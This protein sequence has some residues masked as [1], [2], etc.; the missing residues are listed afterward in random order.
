MKD[1]NNVFLIGRQTRD[2]S[3]YDYGMTG[4]GNA[5]LNLSLAVNNSKKQGDQYVD[6]PSFIDVTVWGHTAENMHTLITK[7]KQVAITGHL[8]QDRWEKDGQ[9]QS[10]L[11]VV[12]D[13]VQLLGGKSGTAA[14]QSE[15]NAGAD[16]FPED[17]NF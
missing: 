10:R 1:L 2:F 14:P 3:E 13:S 12:A 4:S 15:Y 5:R 6:D 16:D 9:K 8:K 11:T 7:G 17:I